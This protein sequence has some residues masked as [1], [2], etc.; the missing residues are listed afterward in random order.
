MEFNNTESGFEVFSVSSTELE[1]EIVN[2]TEIVQERS[3][4]VLSDDTQ[5]STEVVQVDYTSQFDSLVND[6]HIIMF[7]V[8]FSFCWRCVKNWRTKSLK[9]VCK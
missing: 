5:T 8:L 7:I 4:E 6:V 1:S 3:T 9:G 2:D